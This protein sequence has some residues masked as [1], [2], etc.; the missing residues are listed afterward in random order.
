ME[1]TAHITSYRSYGIILVILLFLTAITITVTW[2]DA[3]SLSVGVA[4]FIAC[5]KVSLVLL[6][7]MHLKF[8]ELIF[9]ILAAVVIMLLAV[10]F[11]I[12]FFDYL[13]R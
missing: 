6:Y 4:M 3:G 12:T 8:D 11:I 7:F 1:H 10:V 2:F 5:I 9:K 13:F